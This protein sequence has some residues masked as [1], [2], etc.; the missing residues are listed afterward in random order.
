MEQVR[1]GIRRFGKDLYE[2]RYAILGIFI[3]YVTVHII[4][5]QF[6]PTMILLHLPCPGCGMT[7][8]LFLVLNGRWQLAWR[9]QPLVYGWIF[10]G[11]LFGV[12]RYLLDKKPKFLTCVLVVLLL[13]TILLYVYRICFGFPVELRTWNSGS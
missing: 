2:L 11:V 13:G 9:L 12:N 3:Y 6:C 10:L 4:F 5:G 7:R 1:R 8:A